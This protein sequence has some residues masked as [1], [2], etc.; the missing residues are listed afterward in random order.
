[1]QLFQVLRP[2]IL[3][4][5]VV[6][7]NCCFVMDGIL[8]PREAG[9]FISENSKDVF[10]EDAG[11]Q[12]VANMLYEKS[13]SGEFNVKMWRKHELNPQ[14]MDEE[15]VNWVFV[16]AV[17]NFSFWSEK[18]TERFEVRYKDKT[19]TGYWSLCAAMNRA[20]DEGFKITSASLYST[21]TMD[22][23]KQIFR[24]D[25]ET[26]MPLL[27]ERQVALVEAGTVLM[28]KYQG[29]FANVIKQAGKSAQSLLS[30]VLQ[31]FPSFRDVAEFAGKKVGLYKRAQILV[32]DIWGSCEGQGLG[33]FTDIN[34]ITMFADYRIPQALVYFGALR[35]SETLMEKLKQCH[36]LKSGEKLEV[37]IRGVSLWACELIRDSIAAKVSADTSEDNQLKDEEE[38]NQVNAILVDHYLWDLRRE[39][40]DEMSH[41]PFHRCRGIYY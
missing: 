14:T 4:R 28:K 10:I 33:E 16:S 18:E 6:R 40:A 30:L 15:A 31:E 32:G 41:I 37:E 21:I 39:L 29:S 13:K 8:N 5:L 1:M 19:Y 38:L 2:L 22:Q 3:S 35:Y 7:K 9:R 23:M 25:S 26:E 11:V 12:K 34:T 36:L 17:L 20:L 27:E 24:S